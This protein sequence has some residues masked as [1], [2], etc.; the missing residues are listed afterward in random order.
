MTIVDEYGNVQVL[1]TT[2]GHPFW[3]VMDEPDLS[4]AA[5]EFVL[6]NGTV[7][8]HEN[9]DPG[10]CGFWVEAKDLRPGDV[11]IGANG[12]LSVLVSVE[13]VQFDET[14]KVY[15]FTVDGN[16]DYFVIAKIDNYGQTCILVHNA[17]YLKKNMEKAGM[18]KPAGNYHAHHD[19]PQAKRFQ[20]KW[21]NAG[22][23]N[24][25]AKY[26][27][28]IEGTTHLK[29]S[30]AFNAKWDKFFDKNPGATQTQILNFMKKLRRMEQFQ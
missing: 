20:D 29:W 6:E 1:E 30:K 22:L 14:I 27:R 5:R 16:H 12:E 24:N 11:F 9:I 8:Y 13:R 10:L 23:N 28:W 2:N 7:I 21:K 4:R 15:N 3:V 19:L 18:T 25:V 17:N 26:G